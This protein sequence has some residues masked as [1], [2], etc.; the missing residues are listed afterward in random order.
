MEGLAWLFRA[1]GAAGALY[2]MWRAIAAVLR[3]RWARHAYRTVVA[4]AGVAPGSRQD[5]V[6]GC[7]IAA[8]LGDAVNLPA[9]AV[10]RWLVRLRYPGAIRMRRGLLRFLRRRGDISDDT[11]LTIAVARSILPSGDYC[12]ERF[13]DELGLWSYTRIGAGRACAAAALH[14]RRHG[15][16]K[17]SPSCG[18]GAA[19]RVAP[20]AI[21]MK[22]S[23]LVATVE[24][25]AHATH[26]DDLAVSAAVFQAI[27]IRE[28]LDASEGLLDDAKALQSAIL[29]AAEE[30]G[31]PFESREASSSPPSGHVAE[32]LPAVVAVLKAHGTNFPLAMQ[33][34]FRAGGDTDSIGA[35]VGA[36]IGAQIGCER[37]PKEFELQHRTTLLWLADRLASPR[38]TEA[39]S[40]EI[41]ERTGDIARSESD[42]IVNAWNR[43]LLP[44]WLL[45]PQGVSRALSGAGGRAC[46]HELTKRGPIPLGGSVDTNG[47]TLP[48][49]WIVHADA[50]NMGWR[51]SEL[52]IRRAT[53]SALWLA[54]W[55]GAE[56]VA[57]PML[58]AGSGGV[59]EERARKFIREEAE[60][61]VSRFAR[62]ELVRYAPESRS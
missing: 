7:L 18:N 47:G 6:R 39:C 25:N 32:S 49:R 55:L 59:S 23:E 58:G 4:E 44:R 62:I 60:L 43:N 30:S 16:P 56:T 35:M 46:I 11:Q 5:R 52:S 51:A 20:L 10:P 57:M 28:C 1:V 37:L 48:A 21:A 17:P 22:R 2:L 9:E 12:H 45:V 34:V 27:L 24:R 40:G 3:I 38:R 31:F 41:V 54:H 33:A 36:C 15:C 61:F 29:L 8:G 53:R 14:T 26:A 50:I 42:V 13:L 19:I